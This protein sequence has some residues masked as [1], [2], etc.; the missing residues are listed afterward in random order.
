MKTHY[1][2]YL[3]LAALLCGCAQEEQTTEYYQRPLT[4]PGGKFALLPPAVQNTVR[5]EA[6]MTEL[7]SV[8][9]L[10]TQESPIYAFGFSNPDI[11]PT[12]YVAPDGSVL[13]PDLTVAVGASEDSIAESTGSGMSNIKMD[14]L[15]L[16]VVVTIRQQAPTAEV[17]SITRLTSGPAV[18][19]SVVF[20][21]PL[22]HPRLL[23][24]DNGNVMR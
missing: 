12:L 2:L 7:V 13:R 14:D 1:L 15:P 23:I 5:V 4:S 20:K 18:F 6:G 10:G 11:Y 17:D 22:H 19:Y 16:P 8:E 3:V 9:R 21:D 24:R